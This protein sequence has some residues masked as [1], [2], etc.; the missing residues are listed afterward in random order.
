MGD[1]HRPD[2]HA[3]LLANIKRDLDD[4]TVL[5]GQVSAQWEYEDFVYRFWYRSFKVFAIQAATEKMVA[6]L[7]ALAPN[8]CSLDGWFTQVL[9]EGTSREFS[10]EDN[11]R[12][13]EVTRPM[14]EAFFHARSPLDNHSTWVSARVL[15]RGKSI[16]KEREHERR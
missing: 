3:E 5:L 6:A 14:V 11:E 13:L 1:D 9:A 12:W 10:Y 16:P 7:R 15:H 2:L 4:L 8:G